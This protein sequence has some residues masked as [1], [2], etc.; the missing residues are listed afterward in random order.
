MLHG[1]SE[2]AADAQNIAIALGVAKPIVAVL[3][4]ID[5]NIGAGEGSAFEPELIDMAIEPA[6]VA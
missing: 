2:R 5:I 1:F 4:V 3:E 6:T